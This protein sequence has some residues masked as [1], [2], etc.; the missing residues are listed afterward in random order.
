MLSKITTQNNA[1]SMSSS[2]IVLVDRNDREIGFGDKT[3][4]HQ[5]GS[6]HRAVS[7]IISNSEKE[8]LL[9]KRA[10]QKYHSAGLWSNACCTHPFPNE[11]PYVA[12]CRRLKEELGIS[13][14]LSFMYSIIYKANVPPDLVEHEFVHVFHGVYDGPISP[15][16]AEVEETR[17]VSLENIMTNLKRYPSHFTPWFHLYV[18]KFM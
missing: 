8:M 12:A 1:L 17:W 5:V 16:P 15:C 14:N 11:E 6:L 7:V 2:N 18:K 3:E 4:V 13:A 10:S 9:Q